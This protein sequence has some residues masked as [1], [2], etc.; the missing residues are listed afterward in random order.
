MAASQKLRRL[1]SIRKAEERQRSAQMESALA[2]LRSLQN[3]WTAASKRAKQA[4]ALFGSS[5]KTGELV[6]RLAALQEITAAE[7]RMTV[8]PER[9]AAAEAEVASIRQEYL[10]KRIERRQVESLL[11]AERARLALESNRKSQSVLD[12]WHLLHRARKCK[13]VVP[14]ISE[15]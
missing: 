11:D 7:Y 6:D 15:V 1:H 3:A 5:V 2:K 9:V 10:A 14:K 4:R 12:D 8:L 13:A